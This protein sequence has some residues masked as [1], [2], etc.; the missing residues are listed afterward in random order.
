MPM[1]VEDL[2]VAVTVRE[3]ALQMATN[4]IAAQY[5]EI[6]R[7]TSLVSDRNQDIQW[8]VDKAEE[9]EG[10]FK[11]ALQSVIRLYVPSENR[12]LARAYAEGFIGSDL[13]G[14]S[15]ERQPSRSTY[16]HT[17]TCT[18]GGCESHLTAA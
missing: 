11:R 14:G 17:S 6:Q 18:G 7:L 12:A 15:D 13:E 5:K 3:G 2:Q 9:L 1:A 4:V 8:T 16:P 10:L